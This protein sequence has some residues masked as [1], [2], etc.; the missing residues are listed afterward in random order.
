MPRR[1]NSPEIRQLFVDLAVSANGAAD[2]LEKGEILRA[3]YFLHNAIGEARG[4]EE[5][6][7]AL[8]GERLAH[9]PQP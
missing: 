5:Q 6:L 8:Y 1:I 7:F 9:A 3:L 4:A 2:S